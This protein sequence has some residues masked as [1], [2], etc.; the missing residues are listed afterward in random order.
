MFHCKAKTQSACPN[1][2]GVSIPNNDLD[3]TKDDISNLKY[4]IEKHIKRRFI[5]ETIVS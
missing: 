5:A 1:V 3:T 4:C 2:T